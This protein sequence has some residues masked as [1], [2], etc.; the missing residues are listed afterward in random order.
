ML[1]HVFF[2]LK[3]VSKHLYMD[4]KGNNMDFYHIYS[5]YLHL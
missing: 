5:I 2:S 3:N 4:Q 1:E